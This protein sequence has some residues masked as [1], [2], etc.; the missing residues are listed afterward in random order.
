MVNWD[1]LSAA[2]KTWA[3]CKGHFIE[4]FANQQKHAK[5]EARHAGYGGAANVSE[6][7]STDAEDVA[8]MT[9][10]I[11]QQLNEQSEANFEKMMEKIQEQIALILKM[12]TNTNKPSA[13]ANTSDNTNT[14]S[15]SAGGRTIRRESGYGNRWNVPPRSEWKVGQPHPVTGRTLWLCKNCKQVVAHGDNY[16]LELEKNAH[17]R[18]GKWKSVL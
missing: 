12:A 3:N 5:I 6:A 16:C 9:C 8:M 10:E 7:K 11:I 15:N 4:E 18:P 2:D 13:Q 14:T 1:A 17:R